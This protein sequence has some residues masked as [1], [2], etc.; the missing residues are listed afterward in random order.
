MA[1][2]QLRSL[3]AHTLTIP[4]AVLIRMA[5]QLIPDRPARR[6]MV[7]LSLLDATATIDTESAQ[8][9]GRG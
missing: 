5:A 8:G 6:Q 4:K 3:E 1:L 2:D 7:Q 9:A